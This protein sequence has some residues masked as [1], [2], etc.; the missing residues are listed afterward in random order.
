MRC[1]FLLLVLLLLP[2]TGQAQRRHIDENVTYG[3]AQV[4]RVSPVYEMVRV[5]SVGQRCREVTSAPGLR[6]QPVPVERE[7]RR[8]VGF[9]V[10]YQF[11]GEKYMSRLPSDP[12]SRLRVRMSVVPDDSPP[13]ER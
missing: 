2:L 13:G 3:Y 5:P 8:L 7:E 10:E 11:K 4:L 9:D 6:C 12:G 1:L